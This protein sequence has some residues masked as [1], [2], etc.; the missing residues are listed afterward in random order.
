MKIGIITLPFNINYGGI[1]QNF[2]LQ[3]ILKEMG[4]EVSTLETKRSYKLPV[5][6]RYLAYTKRIILRY[7]FRKKCEIFFEENEFNRLQIISK[8]LRQ[9]IK[10][11]IILKTYPD[12]KHIKENEFD[13]F[14]VGSD[15]IWRPQY[16][17]EIENAFLDFA[18][19]WDVLRIAYAPSFGTDK[20][21]Y[22]KEQAQRCRK[23]IS[24][25][26]GVSIREKEGVDLCNK[27]FSRTAQHVLDPTLLVSK[28]DYIEIITANKTPKSKGNLLVYILDESPEK[29]K[30][31]HQIAETKNLIPFT[32]NN[33][34]ILNYK[35]DLNQ[36]ILPSIE[37]WLRGFYDAEYVIT[38]SFHACVFSIIFQKPFIAY[39]NAQRGLSR[40]T[41]LLSTFHLENRLILNV[42]Q[43][44]SVVHEEIN[45]YEIHKILNKRKNESLHFI[46]QHLTQQ[47]PE[48]YGLQ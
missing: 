12:F 30:I 46:L 48:Q 19:K 8:D 41:S 4:H 10:K 28:E 43:L 36:R 16:F 39:G 33:P 32:V 25:F 5:R 24:L 31:V 14:V 3:K 42:K 45:W 21:E 9:F 18:K 23:L 17:T 15:Q 47:T 27:Y 1:L 34:N 22:S 2:A 35:L 11:Y 26:N 40:F 6:K 29:T 44:D 13:A 38:D 7:L 37:Q 20:W